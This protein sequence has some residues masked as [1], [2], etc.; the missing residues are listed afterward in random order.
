MALVTAFQYGS[1]VMFWLLAVN[2]W[3][4]GH[5]W[6]ATLVW[7]I[8]FGFLVEWHNVSETPAPYDYPGCAATAPSGTWCLGHVAIWVPIGWGSILYLA[9]WSAQRLRVNRWVKPVAAGFLAV[10]VDL[11]LD[12]VATSTKLWHWNTKNG[13]VLVF[14]LVPFDNFLGWYLIVILYALVAREGLRYAGRYAM[15]KH[16]GRRSFWLDVAVPGLAALLALVVYLAVSAVAAKLGEG[17]DDGTGAGSIFIAVSLIAAT[18]T[19]VYTLRSRRDHNPNWA[20]LVIPAAFHAV[21]MAIVVASG[22]WKEQPAL[23]IAIPANLFMGLL[24]FA[25]PSLDSLLGRP[26]PLP[27]SVLGAPP[28]LRKPRHPYPEHPDGVEDAQSG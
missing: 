17:A 9:T 3:R 23:L 22:L 28:S 21:C 19:W 27:I 6:L 25:W 5:R 24:L 1:V 15:R 2:A 14:G 26:A 20:P 8:V 12:P 4:E 7:G 13:E 11:S 18:F 16:G 10:I